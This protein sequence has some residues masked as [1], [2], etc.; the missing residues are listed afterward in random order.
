M[1]MTIT[2][3]ANRVCQAQL[4]GM[5]QSQKSHTSEVVASRLLPQFTH[6]ECALALHILTQIDC[7]LQK[8]TPESSSEHG[9]HDVDTMT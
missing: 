3:D 6:S 9:Q 1:C 5:F 4:S 7:I 8:Q 2:F